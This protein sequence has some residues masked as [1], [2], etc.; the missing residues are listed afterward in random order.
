METLNY[1]EVEL[2]HFAA[3]IENSDDAIISKNLD[4]IITSWNPGAT[5]L[6]GY[7][8]EEIIGRN[9]SIL[10][11]SERLDEEP[12]I[13]RNIQQ[14]QRINHYETVR[15]QKDGK[16]INISLTISPITDNNDQVIGASM[17]ARDITIA[18]E[19]ERQNAMFAAIV[20]SSEDAIVSK[21]LDGIVTSWNPAAERIFGYRADEMIGESITKIIPEDR[22]NEEPMI[23]A[24]IS[25]G[26]RVEHYDTVR[27]R[28]DSSLVDISLTISPI[29]NPSGKIIGASK[30]ARDITNRK[31]Y[32]KKLQEKNI[33][34]EQINKEL[35]DFA[36]IISHDLKAPLRAIGTLSYFIKQDYKD[37]LGPEGTE[38]LEML[39]GR[40]KRMNS[41]ID[42]VLEYSRLGRIKERLKEINI[43]QMIDEILA[44]I[45]IPPGISVTHD[46]LP[47]ILSEKV[48]LSQVFHNLI[49]NAIKFMDKP[50]GNVHI[51]YRELD[52][53]HEFSVRDSGPGIDPKYFDKI[54]QIFQTLQPRD[55]F[56]ST[57]VGLTIAKKAVEM[58]GGKI[59]L[60]SIPGEGSTFYFTWP[61]EGPAI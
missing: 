31:Q 23:I 39:V 27:Q 16:R 26:E 18:K 59:W 49:S 57:G 51:G 8:R 6:F 53:F 37:K 17:I 42:A 61:K 10:I 44:T 41:L 14:G 46:K 47:I 5:K 25:S 3:I 36:Y 56:E 45:T 22:M 38:Q 48:P 12:E 24:R 28:K 19:A 9:I 43:R 21:T 29:K 58:K 7:T 30:I 15:L 54:F 2:R 52:G 32:E 1:S 40:V 55:E 33:E 4:G 34:L 35:N 50:G 11:P 13:M 60:T 20:E